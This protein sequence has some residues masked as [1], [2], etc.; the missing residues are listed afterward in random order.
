MLLNETHGILIQISLKFVPMRKGPINN[1]D[2]VHHRPPCS[3]SHPELNR[4]R[5]HHYSD[6]IMSEV[7]SQITGVS[8]VYSSVCS[9]AD[10]RKHHSSASLAS[11]WGI[12]R[13]P[14]DSPH[15]GPV[16]RKIFPFDDVIMISFILRY[17]FFRAFVIM[18]G[19]FMH[20]YYYYSLEEQNS[21]IS[22]TFALWRV[23]LN[24][25]NYGSI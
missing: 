17:I 5:T 23:K 15:K 25:S 2:G 21:Y 3:T 22:Q 12:H 14:V 8:I 19:S 18:F 7:V 11:M 9:C 13:W 6:V 4:R 1:K 16:T 10:Q 24:S 20:L